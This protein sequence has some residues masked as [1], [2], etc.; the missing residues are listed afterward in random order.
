MESEQNKKGLCEWNGVDVSLTLPPRQAVCRCLCAVFI[1]ATSTCLES[2][3][4]AG[5]DLERKA[6][7]MGVLLSPSSSFCV[8]FCLID[9][10][11]C[12]TCRGDFSMRSCDAVSVEEFARVVEELSSQKNEGTSPERLFFLFFAGSIFKF[13]SIDRSM[14]HVRWESS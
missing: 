13:V 3:C 7:A 6:V 9:S 4:L 10:G 8:G 1:V 5:G 12:G 11:R 14:D 2:S